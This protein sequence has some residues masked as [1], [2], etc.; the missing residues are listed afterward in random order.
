ME[1]LLMDALTF[2]A[3]KVLKAIDAQ[4]LMIGEEVVSLQV[5]QVFSS[6][7]QLSL[8]TD[9]SRYIFVVFSQMV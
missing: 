3:L 6:D 4:N 2:L 5:E 1:V 9:K 7:S 8:K